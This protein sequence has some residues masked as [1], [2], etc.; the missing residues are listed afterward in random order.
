MRYRP[1][2]ISILLLL[3]VLGA[4]AQ[5]RTLDIFSYAAPAGWK[6]VTMKTSMDFET[7]DQQKGSWCR[8][9][10]FVSTVSKGGAAADFDSE[11]QELLMRGY[12]VK[13]KPQPAIQTLSGGWQVL[14]GMAGFV[15]AGQNCTAQLV[16]YT[17]GGRCASALAVYNSKDYEPAIR[18][19]LGSLKIKPG[20]GGAPT[21]GTKSSVKPGGFAFTETRFDDGWVS[22]VKEDWVE[23]TKG[24]CIV[25]LHYPNK[26]AVIAADPDPAA[27]HAWNLLVAPRVSN[28]QGFR[29]ASPSLD[30][31]RAVLATGTV[32]NQ[33][34]RA[35][36]VALFRK[37]SS[38]WLEIELPGKADFIKQFGF[39][40]DAVGWDASSDIWK[41]LLALF[42][43]NK[44]AVGAADLTGT[45]TN[46]FSGVL[47]LYSAVSGNYLG[48]NANQS[49][50]S[51]VF[52]AGNSYSW[53]LLVISGMV[54]NS[55]YN[56]VASKGRFTLKGNW[57][58]TFTDIEGKP[59][60]Y[61]V[62]FSCIKGGRLLWMED[63][64][65]GGGY[66]A[67]GRKEP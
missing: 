35:V 24:N 61:N 41:P 67:Y 62:M 63:A 48:M 30:W 12:S 11:W 39:D 34:G 19:F 20:A 29:V 46:D 64:G 51:F 56:Q 18:N 53:K 49:K 31:Q 23:V 10:L 47:Q 43:Y 14:S 59:R 42:N 1:V 54:G 36:Y 22:V 6:E 50:A 45:W 5:S 7:V 2:G 4:G 13:A 44:F 38:D 32:T 9:Q 21:A 17:N 15:Y 26:A 27:R 8:I 33:Q 60:T 28:L 57:Q 66:S 16:T 37:G 40:P 25:R 55:Q 3:F 58:V 52:G 65:T